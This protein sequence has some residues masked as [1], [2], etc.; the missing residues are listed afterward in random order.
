MAPS[1]DRLATKLEG[2]IVQRSPQKQA[3]LATLGGTTKKKLIGMKQTAQSIRGTL[4]GRK[5]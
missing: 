1:M 5:G 2:K 4:S 3:I